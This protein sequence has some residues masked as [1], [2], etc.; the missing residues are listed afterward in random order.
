MYPFHQKFQSLLAHLTYT[1]A[2][3]HMTQTGPERR[4]DPFAPLEGMREAGF[5]GGAARDSPRALTS[6]T[7]LSL[8]RE[9]GPVTAGGR[10]IVQI[11][12][13]PI[14]SCLDKKS[15]ARVLKKAPFPAR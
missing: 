1:E 2:D 10:Q 15:D 5:P 11:V 4:Q 14:F 12:P 13:G 8:L 6:A 3:K 7:Q 9:Q